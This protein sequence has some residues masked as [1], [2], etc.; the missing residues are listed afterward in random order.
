MF[1]E[2]LNYKAQPGPGAYEPKAALNEKGSYYLSKYKS[3]GATTIDP[4]TSARFKEFMSKSNPLLL[5][6]Q[7]ND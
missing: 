6:H 5:S 4:A 3:S 2:E 1:V 7:T